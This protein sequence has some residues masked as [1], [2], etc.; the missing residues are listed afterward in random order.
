[1]SSL[2][3]YRDREHWSYSSINQFLNICSLQWAFQRLYK[4]PQAFT[5]AALSFGSAFHRAIEWVALTRKDGY[6]PKPEDGAGLFADLWQ[7]QLA[8]TPDVRFDEDTDAESCG[9]QG[10]DMISCAI[11]TWPADERVVSVNRAFAVP[12]VDQHGVALERPLVGELDCVV[13]KDAQLVLIDWKT[14]G[15]RWPKDQASR[16]LQPTAYLYACTQLG[17]LGGTFRFDVIVKNKTPVM[18]S[19]VTTR[20]RD[21]FDRMV[22]LVKRAES[23]IRAEHFLPNEQGFYC[24]GCPFQEPCTAWHRAGARAVSVPA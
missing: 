22:E 17:E 7:R 24:N 2:S 4:L 23:M 1:M 13:E 20:T 21:Q 10:R 16:S 18:E 6:N 5:S 12:L 15:R 3:E 19:H 8:E 9:K 14:S 11:S